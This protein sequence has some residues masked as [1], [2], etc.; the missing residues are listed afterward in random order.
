MKK[1]NEK[2]NK[3]EMAFKRIN[4]SLNEENG[5]IN[6][7]DLIV[8]KHALEKLKKLE[9]ITSKLFIELLGLGIEETIQELDE[10]MGGK[11]DK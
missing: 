11:N 7:K 3:Y 9:T 4:E 8:I 1:Q 2:L 6:D 10:I 5:K